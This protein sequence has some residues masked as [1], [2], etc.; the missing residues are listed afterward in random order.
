[1]EIVV[2]LITA[3]AAYL[4][5]SIP[6]GYL[7]G[8]AKGIDIRQAGS[9]NIGATN[10]FR[11][12]G[13]TAGTIVLL[14]DALKG[15][16]AVAVVPRLIF[17]L[18]FSTAVSEHGLTVDYLKIIGIVVILGHNYPCWLKFKGGKGIATSG[19]VLVAL[20]WPAFLISL[21]VWI[22]VCLITR[23]VS[24]ASIMGALA[25][26]IATWLTNYPIHL[27][28]ITALMS[29]LAIYKH[30]ANIGRLMNGTENKVGRKKG[31]S[32]GAS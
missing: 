4:L 22:L 13:K 2:C 28:A 17:L 18:F 19:G 32:G 31:P 30:K 27:I 7:A 8:R 23:Y 1:V 20:V 16:L 26:P 3:L 6:T 15:W 9:G 21:A 29:A 12:L 25:L 14:V 10:A 24:L 5:G 11:I